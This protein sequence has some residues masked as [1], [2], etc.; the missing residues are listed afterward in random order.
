L[1]R[2][3]VPVLELGME[4]AV[5]LAESMDA[6]GFA[7]GG[8]GSRDRVAGWWGVA[9]LLALGGAFVALIGER[10]TPAA[11]LGLAGVIGLAGA[12]ILA[13]SGEQRVRY[14]PR[15]M[16]LAD[17]TVAAAVLVAPAALALDSIVGDSSLLWFASPLHWP[18]LHVVPTI[19]LLPLLVPV[20]ARPWVRP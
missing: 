10:R 5:T 4:R 14:R 20:V 18:A 1:L 7:R 17:W 13:S 15:R 11:V 16:S 3:T 9:S 12:V 6:R 2:Q 8:A 19:A